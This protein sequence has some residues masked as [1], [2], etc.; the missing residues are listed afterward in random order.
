MNFIYNN[1]AITIKLQL[2]EENTEIRPPKEEEI[3]FIIEKEY[4]MVNSFYRYSEY[5]NDTTRSF[6]VSREELKI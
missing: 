6:L 5:S 1:Q 2:D 3:D 4:Q